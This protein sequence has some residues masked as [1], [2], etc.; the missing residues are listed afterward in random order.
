MTILCED[1]VLNVAKGSSR[2]LTVALLN[3]VQSKN[4]KQSNVLEFVEVGLSSIV[5][6]PPP[7]A[8][9]K[10]SELVD[11][12]MLL[13]YDLQPADVSYQALVNELSWYMPLAQL[14][15]RRV[16]YSKWYIL[17]SPVIEYEESI[18]PNTSPVETDAECKGI[19][20]SFYD[21]G[22]EWF[23]HDQDMNEVSY[24]AT[25]LDVA[26]RESLSNIMESSPRDTQEMLD[27]VT[28]GHYQLK[29]TSLSDEELFTGMPPHYTP[30]NKP[31][32]ISYSAFDLAVRKSCSVPIRLL[33]IEE[34]LY[35]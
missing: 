10:L 5:F 8:K 35:A 32:F 25:M 3:L 21:V 15:T 9:S 28:T 18:T 22:A 30:D 11:N 27:I 23:T 31:D 12:V 24:V 4:L 1:L 19:L 17:N 26:Y 33:P 16:Q 6:A 14:V 29:G 7:L 20:G 34:E 2:A 13:L